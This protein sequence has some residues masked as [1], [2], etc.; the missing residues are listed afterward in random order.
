MKTRTKIGLIRTFDDAKPQAIQLQRS[1]ETASG[2]LLYTFDMGFLM[3]WD[4]LSIPTTRILMKPG[5]RLTYPDVIAALLADHYLPVSF[6]ISC[7]VP[8]A[9]VGRVLPLLLL[10]QFRIA[11]ATTT[12][13][14][15]T[16]TSSS[17][18][19]TTAAAATTTTLT[20]TTTEPNIA[21]AYIT[22]YLTSLKPI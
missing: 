6:T 9:S 3:H 21:V 7:T 16:T 5:R 8:T 2:D 4:P 22:T 10:L 11:A 17:T 18:T 15:S 19:T 1:H 13:T 20:S 14:T 12:T